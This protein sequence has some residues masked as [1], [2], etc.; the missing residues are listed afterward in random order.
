MNQKTKP[1][2]YLQGFVIAPK[3]DMRN[4][5]QYARASIITLAVAIPVRVIRLRV[6]SF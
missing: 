1:C 4:T 5:I 2:R 6:F 3:G